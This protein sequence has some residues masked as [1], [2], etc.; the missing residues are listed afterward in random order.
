MGL[1]LNV[2]CFRQ[3][4]LQEKMS[5][6]S[7]FVNTLL[8]CGGGKSKKVEKQSNLFGARPMMAMDGEN[9]PE[10]AR[11]NEQC[12]HVMNLLLQYG[13]PVNQAEFTS[14]MTALD[15]AILNGD[16]ESSTQ[17]VIAGGDPEHLVKVFSLS[18]LHKAV[19]EGD[20]KRAKELLQVDEFLDIN[21]PFSA[22]SLHQKFRPQFEE[23]PAGS[24]EGLV[25]VAAAAKSGNPEMVRL[26]LKHGADVNDQGSAGKAALHE[27][28]ALGLPKMT[29]MLLQSGAIMEAPASGYRNAT[30]VVI[31]AWLGNSSTFQLLQQVST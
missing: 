30:P 7:S 28:A 27:V 23:H 3:E 4:K 6:K 11:I 9:D 31:A 16:V 26:L 18:D 13:C 15:M 24:D 5:K 8:S 29:S 25:P 19:V 20:N 21:M 12:A 10:V 22:F 2:F 1:E 14:G 17:I